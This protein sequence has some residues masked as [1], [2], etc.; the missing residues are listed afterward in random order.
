MS[1]V[2]EQKNTGRKWWKSLDEVVESPIFRS[3]V[4]AEFPEGASELLATGNDRRHFLKIMGASMALAGLGVGGCRRWPK[5]NIVPYAHRPNGTMPGIAEHYASCFDFGGV[6]QGVVVTSNDGRPTKIEGNPSHPDSRGATDSFTQAAILD[7]YDPDRSRGVTYDNT[8]SSLAAF[9]EWAASYIPN[10]GS[11][12]AVLSEQSSAPTYHRMRREFLKSFPNAVWAEYDPLANQ[13]ERE[14]LHAAFSGQWKSVQDFSKATTIVSFDA[15]F[16]GA[17]PLQVSNTRGWAAHR[18]GAHGKMNRV[19]VAEPAL[20]LTGAN[21]DERLAITPSRITALATYVGAAF[22]GGEGTKLSQEET[23]WADQ[24]IADLTHAGSHG[25]VV[26]GA[27]Q[28]RSVHHLVAAINEAIG[29]TGTT[30]SYTPLG[31]AQDTS[32]EDLAQMMQSNAVESVIVIG[33]N[34]AFDAPS[35]LD[36]ENLLKAAPV[37]IHLSLYEDE[38]SKACQWHVNRAH[39]LESWSDGKSADGTHCIGQPLIRPLFDGVT[40][41]ELLATLAGYPHTDGQTLVQETFGAVDSWDPAWRTAV[42]DGVVQNT[43]SLETPL[44][45]RTINPT[46]LEGEIGTTLVFKPSSSL[47]DG[48]LANNGWMQEIPD[49][50]TKLTW[51]NAAI[52]SPNTAKKFGVQEGDLLEIKVK[53]NTITIAALPVPGTAEDVIVLPLGYGR[54]FA[55]RVCAGAGTDVYPLRGNNVWFARADEVRATGDTYPLATTQMH[56]DLDTTPGKG[57]QERLPLLFREG[58]LEEYNHHPNFAKHVGHSLHS[59]SIFEEEQFKDAQYKWGMSFDL[60]SCT[61]CNACVTACQAENNIAIVG[62]DQVLMGREMQWL[63]IDRY[64]AF[65]SDGHGGWDGDNLDAVAIQPMTCSHCEN[66]PCEEVCPVAAT[67]HDSD[68]LNTM[69]YNRCI[70]TRYCSNNCPFKVR[71]FNYFDY[72]RRDPLRSTGLLQVQPDYYVKA[73][74]G[75]KTLRAMQFNP[76]VT[77]R[78]RGV[79]EKCTYCTQRIQR[80]K[81]ATKNAWVKLSDAEKAKDPRVAIPDGTIVT[82]CEQACPANAIVFGDLFDTNSRVSKLH[83]DDRAYEMLEELNI[84]SRTKYLARLT[85][86]VEGGSAAGGTHH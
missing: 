8:P 27:S 72:F 58:T 63:R 65:Q 1:S 71:R 84:K 44:V 70:G 81:V 6:A 9:K 20:S 10:D 36:F 54:R 41:E 57:T 86:P 66:A 47:W 7:L 48:R 26:A 2:K 39:W 61:G 60:S 21:A 38:T 55:G 13:N 31:A 85:N 32:I 80:A 37:S 83:E 62:K 56:F 22:V 64:F 43:S 3:K 11:G 14:G 75:G 33:G 79:M 68:G 50:I 25:L 59:L 28:P 76:D 77:V 15:D 34:P 46:S 23:A 5:E 12:V 49:T 35:G 78:M 19:W 82:A 40:P 73:Q 74:S 67:V 29:A 52:L 42:H 30:V 45:N 4:Q 51:D 53:K 17:G 16:L 69:V 24:L 18:N